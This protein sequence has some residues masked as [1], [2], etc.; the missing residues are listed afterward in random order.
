MRSALPSFLILILFLIFN[1]GLLAQT[2][3]QEEIK[4]NGITVKAQIPE[5][6]KI[7]AFQAQMMVE[8]KLEEA[9]KAI[10]SLYTSCKGWMRRC[11]KRRLIKKFSDQKKYYY[12]HFGLPWPFQDRDLVLCFLK[13]SGPKRVN[14]AIIAKPTF[15]KKKKSIVRV[16]KING[17]WVL[18]ETKKGRIRLL[19]TMH[20]EPRGNVPAWA[21]NRVVA[22]QAYVVFSNLRKSLR[23]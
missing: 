19:Y 23:R 17:S 1:P 20:I 5:E 16:T 8:A 6:S 7:K 12:S 15:L 21:F 10:E 4:K 13:N 14:I 9:A 3:W 22:K 11:K 18:T 2:K